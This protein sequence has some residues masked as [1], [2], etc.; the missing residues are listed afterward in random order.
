M[1]T[2]ERSGIAVHAHDGALPTPRRLLRIAVVVL[3]AAGILAGGGVGL[4]IR[5]RPAPAAQGSTA[6]TGALLAGAAIPGDTLSRTISRLQERLRTDP[7]DARSW[8]ALGFAY[9]QEARVSAD[10]TYYPK[11][12]GAL[13]RSTSL[14]PNANVEAFAGMASL[15]AARHDFSGALRWAERARAAN[16]YNA[17]VRAILGDALIELGRYQEAFA[18]FQRMIDLRPDV[19]TYARVSYA[20]E[21]Q[22][23]VPGAVRAMEA[24]YRA[25][26]T[27]S[28]SAWASYYL[29]ELQWNQG[30]VARAEAYY[31]RGTRIDP[32]FVPN[33]EGLAKVAAAR[34]EVEQALKDYASVIQRYP[35]P[36]YVLEYGDLAASANRSDLASR[37]YEL[38]AAEVRLFAANG[39]RTDLETAL[40]DADHA[41][42]VAAGLRAARAEWAARHST[43][44]ADALAWALYANG[45][46]REALSFA[47][48]ALALGTKSAPFL[49]HRGMIERAMG[50]RAAAR[51]DIAEAIDINPQFSFLWSG[52]AAGILASLGGRS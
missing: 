41:R 48:R 4:W 26:G 21:L 40:F 14:Q 23:N 39:V 27:P 18:Q 8:A 13:R 32:T 50:R 19:S 35:L 38:F 45:R 43:T 17:T 44:V 5:T 52:R 2:D 29:G 24:A 6:T 28:D 15:A 36:Q 37:Q 10:P 46:Y 20:Q 33:D 1:M 7:T 12:E 22:G 34:G 51:Q 16:P 47:N 11:A 3:L 49:F 31:L 25:A 30:N 42:D 9:V